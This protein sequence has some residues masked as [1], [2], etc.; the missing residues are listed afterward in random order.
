MEV[1]AKEMLI[2]DANTFVAEIGLTSRAGSALKHYLY[3]RG[4]QLVVPEVIAEE[5]GRNLTDR[6]RGKEKKYRRES[7]MAGTVLRRSEWMAGPKR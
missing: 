4:M 6:A 2:L 7:A 1:T 3:R 5:C